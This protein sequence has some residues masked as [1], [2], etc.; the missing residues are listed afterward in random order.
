MGASA[1]AVAHGE[2]GNAQIISLALRNRS[3]SAAGWHDASRL[4]HSGPD[5]APMQV[6]AQAAVIDARAL[7]A[8]QRQALKAALMAIK[9]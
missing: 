8:E 5:G 6:E 7:T 4:E 9:V 1:L 2:G 3:R